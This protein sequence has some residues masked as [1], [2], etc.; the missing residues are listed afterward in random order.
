VELPPRSSPTVSGGNVSRLDR[1][2][3]RGDCGSVVGCRDTAW[4]GRV[5]AGYSKR[6][7]L[8]REQRVQLCRRTCPRRRR[9]FDVG[10][11]LVANAP[12]IPGTPRTLPSCHSR[13]SGHLLKASK[14]PNCHAGHCPLQS[15]CPNSPPLQFRSTQYPALQFRTTPV[16]QHPS[17]PNPNSP[18]PRVPCT[19]R[20]R[21]RTLRGQSYGDRFSGH[22]D[23]RVKISDRGTAEVPLTTQ[24]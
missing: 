17:K 2:R 5:S 23:G 8:A 20:G 21:D 4:Q 6:R 7:A 18:F 15:Q 13:D 14:P 12:R 22:S 11:F 3:A 16:P 1:T 24:S 19:F 9:W 10:R